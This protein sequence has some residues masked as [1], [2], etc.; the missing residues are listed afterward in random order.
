MD[1]QPTFQESFFHLWFPLS[2]LWRFSVILSPTFASQ[3][4]PYPAFSF[5]FASK[6]VQAFRCWNDYNHLSLFTSPHIL[7][8]SARCL[9][10]FTIW[11]QAGHSWSGLYSLFSGNHGDMVCPPARLGACSTAFEAD[12][13][14]CDPGS[15]TYHLGVLAQ[16]IKSFFSLLFFQLKN[17]IPI[18]YVSQRNYIFEM[19]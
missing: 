14:A 11:F 10:S 7:E 9:H 15:S 6:L 5:L 19:C 4:S 16:C 13:L 8:N 2:P 18:S 12:C 1:A 17:G 3:I